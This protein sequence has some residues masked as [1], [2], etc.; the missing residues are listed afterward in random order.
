[1]R[2]PRADYPQPGE[3]GRFAQKLLSCNERLENDVA[4]VRAPVQD[5]AKTVVRHRIDFAIAPGDGGDN[6]GTARE[7]RRLAREIAGPVHDD[8][9][10]CFSSFIAD[11][12]LT[13]L[14]DEELGVAV[15]ASKERLPGLIPRQ[16]RPRATSQSCDLSFIKLGKCDRLQVVFGHVSAF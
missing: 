5:L 4:Q 16:R 12:D 11:L 14:D 9:S 2:V 1:M 15:A 6:R 7:L 10:G 8:E 3:A 13:R